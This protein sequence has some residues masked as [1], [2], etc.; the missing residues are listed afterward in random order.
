MNG[1]DG[2][3][4]DGSVAGG[5]EGRDIVDHGGLAAKAVAQQAAEA[6]FAVSIIVTIEVIVAHLVYD[7]AYNQLRARDGSG[8]CAC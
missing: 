3:G 8:L 2:A 6:I 1:G 7:Y 4:I 5:C